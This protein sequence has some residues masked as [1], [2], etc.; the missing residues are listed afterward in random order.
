MNTARLWPAG[1]VLAALGLMALGSGRSGAGDDDKETRDALLKI[2][3]AIKAGD[4]AGAKKQAVALA[5]NID[6][7][8]EVMD[9]L[10]PRKKDKKD[11]TGKKYIGGL[12]LG[13][14]PG[15]ILPD[16]IEV[17]L[18]KI[19]GDK[20]PPMTPA[21]L[22]KEGDALHEAA[23]VMAA[24]AEVAIADAAHARRYVPDKA[25]KTKKAWIEYAKAMRDG[26]TQFAMA[27]KA[28]DGAEVKTAATKL[29][30]TCVTCHNVF[31]PKATGGQ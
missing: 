1:V 15:A 18:L 19:A 25:P 6:A 31:K 28:K 16:G 29:N 5:K 23:Y 20:E 14:T 11:K 7:I 22:A 2:A 9:F 10:K 8:G 4:D 13:P 24:I 12:G 26:A 27:A 21:A 30:N 3:A 17:K